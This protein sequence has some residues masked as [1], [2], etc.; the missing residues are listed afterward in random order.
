MLKHKKRKNL[1][2]HL[3]L[4]KLSTST[5]DIAS[6]Q[7]IALENMQTNSASHSKKDLNRFL[8]LNDLSPVKLREKKQRRRHSSS[9]NSFSFMESL[10]KS[11]KIFKTKRGENNILSTSIIEKKL[12]RNLLE[13]LSLEDSGIEKSRRSSFCSVRSSATTTSSIIESSESSEYSDVEY[14][15]S[16]DHKYSR[17]YTKDFGR[18]SA[19]E[20]GGFST[21][22]SGRFSTDYYHRFSGSYNVGE[23]NNYLKSRLM[24]S[25][26]LPLIPFPPVSPVQQQTTKSGLEIFSDYCNMDSAAAMM[27]QAAF[28]RQ[29]E[30]EVSMSMSTGSN[31]EMSM[32]NVYVE[33]RK[34]NNCKNEY[35]PKSLMI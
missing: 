35:V 16:A 17:Y 13:D 6:A 12:R 18:F 22:E 5:V 28:N 19:N 7:K 2:G 10:K 29:R 23:H 14:N 26:G 30:R 9:R 4:S 11:N 25:V 1:A 8:G 20:F 33:M 3:G 24:D 27:K 21:K 31:S 15:L 34:P 32:D